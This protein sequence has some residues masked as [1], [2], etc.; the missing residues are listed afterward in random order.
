MV[1]IAATAKKNFILDS[2]RGTSASD[3][4]GP[5]GLPLALDLRG[6]TAWHR[7]EKLEHRADNGH[8]RARL[9]A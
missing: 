5:G 6:S 4:G 2:C 9:Q 1:A 3:G 7:R 8:V